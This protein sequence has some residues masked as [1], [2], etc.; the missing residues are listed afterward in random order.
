MSE[1]AKQKPGLVCKTETRWQI[2]L[3]NANRA[4][5][6]GWARHHQREYESV[7]ANLERVL[8]MLNSGATLGSFRLDFFRSE[9]QGLWRIGQTGVSAAKE[10]RLYLFMDAHAKLAHVLGIGG[11][12]SQQ[13][14]IKAARNIIGRIQ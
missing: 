3:G 6:A 13:R 1:K 2:N 12:E 14:D 4:A 9:K 7:F 5:F 11:K 10:T 8:A